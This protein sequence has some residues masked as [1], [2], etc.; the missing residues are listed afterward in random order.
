LPLQSGKVPSLRGRPVRQLRAAGA[1]QVLH[2]VASVAK[3]DRSRR[4]GEIP[5][6]HVL[7]QKARRSAENGEVSARVRDL[8]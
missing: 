5:D 3:T 7:E 1:Y 4:R 8:F 2:E 6:K